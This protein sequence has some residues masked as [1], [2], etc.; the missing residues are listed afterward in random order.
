MVLSITSK[1]NKRAFEG[2]IES[3]LVYLLKNYI[4]STNV[5]VL[6]G[7]IDSIKFIEKRV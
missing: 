5:S 4:Y 3:L 7:I 2:L 1:T 6:N